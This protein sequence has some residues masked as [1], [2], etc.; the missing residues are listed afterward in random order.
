MLVLS[1]TLVVAILAVRQVCTDSSWPMPSGPHDYHCEQPEQQQAIERLCSGLLGQG[2]ISLG[3]QADG[4]LCVLDRLLLTS[5]SH[6]ACQLTHVAHADPRGPVWVP[7]CAG[8]HVLDSYKPRCSR[9]R[10]A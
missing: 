3:C 1:V 4:P 8:Q 5:T 10:G 7:V 6:V 2:C 9:L